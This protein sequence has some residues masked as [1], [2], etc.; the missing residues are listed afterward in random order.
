MPRPIRALIDLAALKNNFSVARR[1]AGSARVMAVLKA[2]AYGH[3]A[4]RAARVFSDADA[5]AVLDVDSAVQLRDAGFLQPLILLEGC[6]DAH[7]VAAAFSHEL[8]P[9][10]HSAEQWRMFERLRPASPL[11]VMLKLNTGMNRLGLT[12]EDLVALLP[13]VRQHPAI[14]EVIL[15]THFAAADESGGTALQLASFHRMTAGLPFAKSI[16]NSAALLDNP[17][18]C[19]DWVRPGIALYGAS[20]F[21]DRSAAS[22]GLL[23]AMTLE[24]QVIA[25]QTLVQGDCVGYGATFKATRPMRVGIVACGYADGYPRHAESGTPVLVCGV[26]TGTL[27]RVSMDMLCVDLTDIAQAGIGSPV[28]LWGRGLPVE[29]VARAAKTISYELLCALNARVASVETGG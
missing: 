9:V 12:A 28:V 6:F 16:A 5:F 4:L 15:M 19:A 3:G 29:E 8:T 11:G 21:A 14:G 7:D 10:I 22:L 24:S 25:T 2:N 26:Q 20:P 1:H 13:T 27:G 17:E 18:T 23:P